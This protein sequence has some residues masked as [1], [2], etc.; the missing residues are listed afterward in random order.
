ME[1]GIPR[2]LLADAAK[3]PFPGETDHPAKWAV[4]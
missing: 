3:D 4:N 1:V 2:G